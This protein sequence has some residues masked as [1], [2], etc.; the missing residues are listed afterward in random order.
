MERNDS[1]FEWS[2]ATALSYWIPNIRFVV[3]ATD[4]RDLNDSSMKIDLENESSDVDEISSIETNFIEFFP[5]SSN[6]KELIFTRAFRRIIDAKLARDG[7]I[8]LAFNFNIAHQLKN[9]PDFE[10][11]EVKIGPWSEYS[12]IPE[13]LQKSLCLL[14]N[15]WRRHCPVEST[16][17]LNILGNM[18][19][20]AIILTKINN[21]ARATES[22]RQFRA[23]LEARSTTTTIITTTTVDE[24]GDSVIEKDGDDDLEEDGETGTQQ[25][26]SRKNGKRGNKQQHI[27]TQTKRPKTIVV[28]GSSFTAQHQT[29]TTPNTLEKRSSYVDLTQDDDQSPNKIPKHVHDVVTNFAMFL[30]R[31]GYIENSDEPVTLSYSSKTEEVV[32]KVKGPSS[33][34]A[35]NPLMRLKSVFKRENILYDCQEISSDPPIFLIQNF[36]NDL[37]IK[38]FQDY[39]TN[40]TSFEVSSTLNENELVR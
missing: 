39:I 6:Y 10:S 16:D 22:W 2:I 26:G 31:N 23:T 37:E 35:F 38:S 11:F 14:K 19:F 28:P 32:F 24:P 17:L 9:T 30:Q 3:S 25:Q 36:F 12:V 34:E 29:T 20:E 7:Q 21:S 1:N 27:E 33:I 5:T 4:P 13:G 8:L 40:E 15:A 18:A